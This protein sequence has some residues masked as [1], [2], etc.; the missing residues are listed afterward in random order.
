MEVK[1]QGLLQVWMTRITD[2]QKDCCSNYE[3]HFGHIELK[4]PNKRM[5]TKQM[6]MRVLS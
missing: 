6:A 4:Q 3:F 2:E 5:V 1:N